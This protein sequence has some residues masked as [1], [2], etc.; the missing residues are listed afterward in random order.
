MADPPGRFSADGMAAMTF[1]FG[2]S[3]AMARMVARAAAAP[4]M[5]AFI[6]SICSAFLMDSPPESKVTPL[7]VMAIGAAL[8]PPL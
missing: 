3:C 6:H 5:S 1:T 7:P 8:P 4:P 2:W